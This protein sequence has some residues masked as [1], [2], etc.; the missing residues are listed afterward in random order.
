MTYLLLIKYI[1][2]KLAF[3]KGYRIWMLNCPVAY[4]T[5]GLPKLDGM[6]I[7]CCS[8][9]NWFTGTICFSHPLAI[10]CAYL[11]RLLHEISS[12]GAKMYRFYW[13]AWLTWKFFCNQVYRWVRM[14]GSFTLFFPGWG[15]TRQVKTRI[16]FRNVRNRNICEKLV[17]NIFWHCLPFL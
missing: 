10:I 9:D 7:A 6:I 2:L 3:Y 17:G 5:V 14:V 8:Q 15:Q 13:A 11:L 12:I 4:S 16:S 1:T